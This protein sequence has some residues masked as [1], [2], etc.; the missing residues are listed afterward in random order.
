MHK[1]A[2]GSEP[3]LLIPISV[4]LPLRSGGKAAEKTFMPQLTLCGDINQR[5][6]DPINDRNSDVNIFSYSGPSHLLG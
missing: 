2:Q 4:V 5:E 3:E 6:L 1:A